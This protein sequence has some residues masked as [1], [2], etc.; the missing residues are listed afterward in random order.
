M[1]VVLL[2]CS[3]LHYVHVSVVE[4]FMSVCQDTH[5]LEDVSV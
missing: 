3:L 4:N 1:R 5:Y 2:S